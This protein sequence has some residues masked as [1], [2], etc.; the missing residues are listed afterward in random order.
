MAVSVCNTHYK[1]A[2]WQLAAAPCQKA[3]ESGD[4]VAQTILGELYDSGDGVTQDS[5]KAAHWWGLASNAG[6]QPARNLLAM[7]H[8]YGGTVFGPEPG[9]KK[10][11][12]KAYKIWH[13]DAVRGVATSQFMLGVMYKNGE[14]LNGITP[15]RGRG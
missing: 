3:S 12:A 1:N 14:G 2:E 11:Y 15:S 9:W 10:D 4:H 5:S 6:H 8:Y 7:K 13:E